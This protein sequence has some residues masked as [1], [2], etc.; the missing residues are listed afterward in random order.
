ME[1]STITKLTKQIIRKFPEM[2]GVRP[3]L[4]RKGGYENG[5]QYELTFKSSAQLPGGRTMRRVVRV[6][7]D[8]NGRILRMST[9]K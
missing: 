3:S 4:K 7:A 5:A 2:E 9:S 8:E 1:K 6:I